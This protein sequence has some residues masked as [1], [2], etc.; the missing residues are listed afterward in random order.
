MLRGTAQLGRS[1]KAMIEA[2]TDVRQISRLAY[3]ATEA[4]LI[5][6]ITRT[7]IARKRA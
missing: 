5:P 1:A 3:G 6:E 2:L 4:V 7:V